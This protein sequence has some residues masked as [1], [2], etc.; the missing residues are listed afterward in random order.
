MAKN[1]EKNSSPL[2]QT[3]ENDMTPSSSITYAN[4]VVEIIAG[5]AAGEVEGIAG[6]CNV[7]SNLLNKNRNV[8]RGIKV[9]IGT[10]EVAVD[11]YVIMEY[12]TPIQRAAMDAQENVR[13]AI[14][15]MTGL[16]VV[17]VDVHV[18]SVSFEKENRALQAGAQSA[19]LE[20]G[21]EQAPQEEHAPVSAEKPAE[22]AAETVAEETAEENE[23]AEQE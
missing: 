7:N 12:G 4:E 13:K 3:T 14:E 8:T 16:H 6:M 19:V 11:L 20:A 15:S 18:Q 21:T 10:E 17:R 5:L 9:E 23:T 22:E 2:P 1:R